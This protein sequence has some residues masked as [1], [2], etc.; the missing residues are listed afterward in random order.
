MYATYYDRHWGNENEW[1]II[2]AL[3]KCQVLVEETNTQS[4]DN[5]NSV[6]YDDG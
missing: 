1:G 5:N 2:L 3:E 6:N 4:N